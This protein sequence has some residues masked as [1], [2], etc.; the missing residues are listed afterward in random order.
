MSNPMD[1]N[2]EH[3]KI[4]MVE[5]FETIEG[6]GT[7]A[8]Y[9]TIFVRLFGCNLRCSWCDTP[10][11]YPPEK[12]GQVLTIGKIVEQVESYGATHL[13]LTGGE[14]LLYGDHSLALLSALDS[15]DQLE[16][17]HVETNGAI[18][19]AP[20]LEG[21]VS[22]KVRYI[23]DFKLTGSGERERMLPTNLALLREQ[24]ELKFVVAGE[25]DFM[26]ACQVLE[27]YP[28]SALPLFSPVWETMPPRRLAE[29][30]LERKLPRARLNLQLHKIIWDPQMRG[31]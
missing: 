19:L 22:E 9:P 14:P 28:T 5:I 1:N 12:A 8:G 3:I 24:D 23:M 17:I 20:F 6:E 18:D 27:R 30:L 26:E 29:L 2:M 11:S 16:D 7:R 4:P 13:C 25:A 31:V 15:L 21:I 10:Y